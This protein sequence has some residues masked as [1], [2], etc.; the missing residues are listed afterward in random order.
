MGQE[1]QVGEQEQGPMVT[2]GPGHVTACLLRRKE[3]GGQSPSLRHSLNA[4]HREH[5]YEV[6]QEAKG[7]A[8]RAAGSPWWR[9]GVAG[10]SPRPGLPGPF[11]L[12]RLVRGWCHRMFHGPVCGSDLFVLLEQPARH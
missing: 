8:L 7:C 1:L 10:E 3:G 4:R 12:M 9:L 5:I 11:I 6:R 2:D